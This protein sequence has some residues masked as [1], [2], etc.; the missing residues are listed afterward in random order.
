MP[1]IPQNLSWD[2]DSQ[3]LYCDEDSNV[4]QYC[5]SVFR[6]PSD[7]EPFSSQIVDVPKAKF[8]LPTGMYAAKAKTKANG[9]GWGVYC[10]AIT[11]EVV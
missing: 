11:I 4:E 9:G 6:N 1:N 5:F 3:T 8:S 7:T 2:L 10:E